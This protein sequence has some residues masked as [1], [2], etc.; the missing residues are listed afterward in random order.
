MG[1][2][3]NIPLISSVKSDHDGFLSHVKSAGF[4][5]PNTG[6]V[7]KVTSYNVTPYSVNSKN[8]SV[9]QISRI[10]LNMV[11]R[12]PLGGPTI[13]QTLNFSPLLV[14]FDIHCSP[15][16]CYLV[17]ITS[18]T[19]LNIELYSWQRTHFDLQAK[20]SSFATPHSVKLFQIHSNFYVAIAQDQLHLSPKGLTRDYDEPNRFIGCAILRFA[21]GHEKAVE[22]HQFIKLPFQPNYVN[23]YRS[24]GSSKLTSDLS[25]RLK[26]NSY[27]V[28][29][30]ERNPN[31]SNPVQASAFIWSPLNEYFWPT[32]LAHDVVVET[33]PGYRTPVLIF[34]GETSPINRTQLYPY[35]R[36]Q[37]VEL[38]FDQLQRLL[39]DRESYAR[40]LIDSSR[41]IWRS[42][43]SLGH[44]KLGRAE[45][46]NVSAQVIV[47]GNVLVEGSLIESPQISLIGGQLPPNVTYTQMSTLIDT[48]SPTIVENKLRQAHYKLR[49]M[50]EKLGRATSIPVE[51]ETNYFNGRVRFFG[52]IYANRVIFKN[53]GISNS[54]VRL[55]GIPFHQLEHEL[56]SLRGAQEIAAGVIFEGNVVADLLEIHGLINGLYMLRDAVDITSNRVQVIDSNSQFAPNQALSFNSISTPDVILSHNASFNNVRLDDFITTDDSTQIIHGYKSFRR[57][58]MNQL[59]LA[60]SNVL[61]N[62]FNIT[63]LALKALYK[64]KLTS[65]YQVINADHVTFSGPVTADRLILNN[66]VNGHV[67]IT[68]LI[69]DSVKKFDINQ[70][71]ISGTKNF[72][73]GLRIARM[74][75]EGSI[76]G[77]Q[78]SQVFN[79]NP[80][81]PQPDLV[82]FANASAF[83]HLSA[84]ILGN[85]TFT[86]PVNIEGN[87]NTGLINGVNITMRAIRRFPPASLPNNTAPQV[88]RG[89]KTF[90]RPLRIINQVKL[91]QVQSIGQIPSLYPLVNGIDLRLINEGIRRQVR[92]PP[93]IYIDN[94]EID[95]NLNLFT[96]QNRSAP[97]TV[98]LGN[99]SH[100]PLDAIRNKLVLGGREDQ[101]LTIPIRVKT[102]RSRFLT[103]ESRALNGYDIENDFVLRAGRSGSA[104]DPIE[105]IF[106]NKVFEHLFID[107]LP[108][109]LPPPNRPQFVSNFNGPRNVVFG[110]MVKLNGITQLELQNFV[111]LERKKNTT[112]ETVFPTLDVYGD[113][114]A[115]TINGYRWPADILLKSV[116]ANSGAA[117]PPLAHRR[118]YSPLVFLDQSTL[119]VDNQLVLR[120]PIQLAGRMNGVNLTEFSHQSA[121]YGDKDLMS[122][123]RPI[124]NK[125]FLGGITVT[126]ELRSQGLIDGINFDEMRRR[127]VRT[128]QGPPGSRTRILGQKVFMSDVSF[129]APVNIVYLND[130]ALDH[131]LRRIQIEPGNDI[132]RVFGKKSIT[133]ALIIR[134]DLVVQ[135]LINGFNFAELEARAIR[136]SSERNEIQ[137]NETLTIEGNVFMD[138]LLI[139]ERN[140]IIDGVKLRN[141]LP[142]NAVGNREFVLSQPTVTRQNLTQGYQLNV[143]G[144]IQDCQITCSLSQAASPTNLRVITD[145]RRVIPQPVAPPPISYP[146]RQIHY[147]GQNV[148]YMRT[149]PPYVHQV[150]YPLSVPSL[151]RHVIRPPIDH[152]RALQSL[153]MRP[154]MAVTYEKQNPIKRS[155]I[156]TNTL[157][158]FDHSDY[159]RRQIHSLNLLRLHSSS[160]L[161]IGFIEAPSN[162]ISHL[163]NRPR[164]RSNNF[165]WSKSFLQLDQIDF[166]FQPTTYH[167]SVGV[168]TNYDGQ[169]I[170]KVLSSLGGG[171]FHQL[172]SLPIESP[173]SAMFLRIMEQQTLFLLISQDYKTVASRHSG[174]QCPRIDNLIGVPEGVQEIGGVH[175]YLFHALQNSSSLTSA[176]F[177]LYQT[178]DLAG[179]D[180]FESF[181]YRGSTYALAISRIASRVYV[182]LLRGYAGFQVV[183]YVDC[184]RL[185]YVKIVYTDSRRPTLIVYQSN[186]V[187][188]LMEAVI[189]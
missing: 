17:A 173:N 125:M 83:A 33:R 70:Q 14:D 90:Y 185:D 179:I 94:L 111:A 102:L 186:G 49:Y 176:Y 30:V 133:G 4:S 121:T 149:T 166:P 79:L 24:T 76:N 44:E 91:R 137:F 180:G 109:L 72:S 38:C 35:G 32:R 134:R 139:D 107:P 136:L 168:S 3:L 12:K 21:R 101:T 165:V 45:Q 61:L 19:K 114:T 132:V 27:V 169:N 172:S 116:G 8:G 15:S 177:D 57:L 51:R 56:V 160:N 55:N 157:A 5:E 31:L 13:I 59:D 175:V 104:Y 118:I 135:G 171:D 52:H 89:R 75:T 117:L 77:I 95:G 162:D 74:V 100:C 47:H 167:L 112:G 182:M 86:S 85:Y 150:N 6:N 53:N 41:S 43:H 58:A 98:T 82:R 145:E 62:N 39:T 187:H 122:I 155:S 164:L 113:I 126:G 37:P 147:N 146:P 119:R 188:V 60:D 18:K 10:Q 151:T 174:N 29:S 26:E 124:R 184:P 69:H 36:F 181:S 81:P 97:S 115:K 131:H 103:L 96:H 110:P 42:T 127:V 1:L 128:S 46:A 34:P 163:P 108:P 67:N 161:V 140:G 9:I 130:L 84:P 40:K 88:V 48:H 23:Y 189:I 142:I 170:T 178:I 78:M 144:L 2:L 25:P 93:L 143:A 129:N 154:P 65:D 73:K 66:F 7:Y 106:G 92:N 123:A 156:Q 64:Q 50:R 183:S 68:T 28:F 11:E 63:H 158:T 99:F 120:G 141:L 54:N 153:A 87:L 20:R 152:G 105:H 148:S 16:H 71:I 138:N 159:L 22:Y 80:L